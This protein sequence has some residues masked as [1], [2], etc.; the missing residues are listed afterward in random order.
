MADDDARTYI[1]FQRQD[2]SEVVD[3][4]NVLMA[5]RDG[6]WVNIEPII[7][8]VDIDA[9][10]PP[11]LLTKLLSSRGPLI[12]FGTIMA[13]S[14]RGDRREPPQVGLQHG[15]GQ[16]AIEQLADKGIHPRPRWLR[17]DDS[18][19]R[20]MVFRI[21]DDDPVDEVIEWVLVAAEALSQV[22]IREHW[23][24]VTHRSC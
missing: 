12:P 24:A 18:P 9:V 23:S 16:K 5:R 7:H 1:E 21:P 20:G 2:A 14:D 19:K 4:V 3:A 22:N 13:P 15:A 8:Q 17:L 10:K 6:S 11:S